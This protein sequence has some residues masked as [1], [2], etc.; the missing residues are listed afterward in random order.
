M[1]KFCYNFKKTNMLGSFVV[2]VVILDNNLQTL[3]SY[4]FK[5]VPNGCAININPS[6]RTLLDG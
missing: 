2:V 6:I 1:T 3:I 5:Y 4:H